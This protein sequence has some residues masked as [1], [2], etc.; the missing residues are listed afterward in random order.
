MYLGRKS[1]SSGIVKLRI[2]NMNSV[3]QIGSAIQTAFSLHFHNNILFSGLDD[4]TIVAWNP[5]T[6]GA[7]RTYNGHSGS[8]LALATNGDELYSAGVDKVILQWNIRSGELLQEFPPHH[9]NK[10][11]SL[12][13][14]DGLIFSA[15]FDAEIVQWNSTTGEQLRVFK[16][17]RIILRSVA[18]WKNFVISAG[19]E[20]KIAIW[21]NTADSIE[22]LKILTGHIY[23]IN[24]LLVSGDFLFT[25]SSDKTVKQW[26]L[27]ND[28]PE[29]EFVGK[30]MHEKLTFRTSRYCLGFDN[31]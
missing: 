19:E 12:A 8:V 22:P 21:D 26:K 5:D 6:G 2:S 13:L 23:P 31:K 9:I 4:F 10:I 1:F 28:N 30:S 18:V 17:S 14:K 15:A 25:G 20:S 11:T 7:I 16:T 3:M 24:C 29:K 27:M